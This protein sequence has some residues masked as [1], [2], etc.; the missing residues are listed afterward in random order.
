MIPYIQNGS[1]Q[2]PSPI[3]PLLNPADAS[4]WCVKAYMLILLLLQLQGPHRTALVQTRDR[5]Q[6]GPDGFKSTA[7][8]LGLA[9]NDI[10]HN[11][12]VQGKSSQK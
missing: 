8:L 1:N 10:V 5:L 7:H 12:Q 11:W 9:H 6:V 2:N 3:V 4:G